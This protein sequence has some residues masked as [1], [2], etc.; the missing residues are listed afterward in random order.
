[1]GINQPDTK[2]I[3]EP[4]SNSAV[5]TWNA[6]NLAI[7]GLNISQLLRALSRIKHLKGVQELTQRLLW[8][9]LDDHSSFTVLDL[10]SA[11]HSAVT[12]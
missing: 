1:M 7:S 11:V 10:V 9:L 8:R 2:S 6:G 12:M 5:P 4:T 3:P